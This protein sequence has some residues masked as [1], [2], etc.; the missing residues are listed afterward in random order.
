MPRMAGLLECVPTEPAL[1]APSIGV[2]KGADLASALGDCAG[3]DPWPARLW[4]FAAFEAAGKVSAEASGF[5][6]D[7]GS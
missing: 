6:V 5:A 2:T 1:R 3:A 4:Y 7:H